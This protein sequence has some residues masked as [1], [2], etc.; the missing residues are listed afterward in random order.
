MR[1]EVVRRQEVT[2]RDLVNTDGNAA[3][4][5]RKSRPLNYF[6]LDVAD[7]GAL[8]HKKLHINRGA[9]TITT[10]CYPLHR[11]VAYTYSDVQVRKQPAF[12]TAEVAKMLWRT[13][14]TLERAILDGAFEAPQYTYGLNEHK[15]KYKFMWNEKDI[16]A[17]HDYFSSVHVGRPRK[18]GL[19]TPMRLP[20]K[21]ELRA[22]IRQEQILYVRGEDGQFRPTW[23]AS[24]FRE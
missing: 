15:R 19:V 21:R 12:T 20:T 4:G 23:A 6:Y 7:K 18:D 14:L 9:D 17:A 2:G 5:R 10:W 3:N 8:L 13:R 11:R 24:D 16:F 1:S 22:M